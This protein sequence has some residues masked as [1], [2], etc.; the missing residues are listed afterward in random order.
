[1][2]YWVKNLNKFIKAEKLSINE[3]PL[4]KKESIVWRPI[5]YKSAIAK[6]KFRIYS[7]RVGAIAKYAIGESMPKFGLWNELSDL[8][9]GCTFEE[10]KTDELQSVRICKFGIPEGRDGTMTIPRKR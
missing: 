10:A 6:Y 8:P 7:R 5:S 4:A 2:V 1:M 9:G 3:M